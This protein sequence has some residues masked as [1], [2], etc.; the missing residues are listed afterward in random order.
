MAAKPG[1]GHT[2]SSCFQPVT[3]KRASCVERLRA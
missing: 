2:P 1:F 3:S